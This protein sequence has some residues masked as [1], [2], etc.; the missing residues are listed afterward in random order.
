MAVMILAVFSQVKLSATISLPAIFGDHMVI[1][2]DA[3]ITIWGWGKAREPLKITVSWDPSFQY[4]ETLGKSGKWSTKLKSPKEAGPH[5]IT[6]KG[7]NSIIISDVLAGEVWLCSGQSNM[8]WTTNGKIDGGEE[9]KKEANFPQIRF[10]SVI[11]RTSESPQEDTKGE[12]VICNPES[13]G[14][15]SAA[16]YFFGKELHQKLN[17]PVG[18]ISSS[19]GGSPAEVWIPDS[20]IKN[21]RILREAATKL[22]DEPWASQTPG[23]NYNG[24]IYPLVPFKIAGAIWYQGE[25]NTANAN[26]YERL[27]STLID[28]WRDAWGDDFAFYIAQIAPYKGYGTDNNNGA[29]VRAQQS[30]V[31]DKVK[32]VDIFALSDIGN[33][34]DIHP[35]NKID[36]GKRFAGLALKNTYKIIDTDTSSPRYK[37]HELKGETV[38]IQFRNADKG[39]IVQGNVLEGFEVQDESGKWQTADAKVD[40]DKVKVQSALVKKPINVRFAMYNDSTP[41]LFNQNGLP[42]S[43]FTTE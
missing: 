31:A 25:T 8:E 30:R 14:A 6:V 2:R 9:A 18:L 36:V 3:E 17:R 37:C 43:C 27:L 22:R 38:V 42:A 40:G 34:D 21:D 32:N 5:T 15:F 41:N 24:M 13:M 7:Y 12:W 39:L 1:Q 16:A 26:T 19:W 28:S 20:A 29:I 4:S 33:L 11:T 10:F 23:V 35:K